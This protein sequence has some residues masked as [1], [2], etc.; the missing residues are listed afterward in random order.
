MSTFLSKT[1][2]FN[3]LIT[4]V[5]V[6]ESPAEAADHRGWMAEYRAHMVRKQAQ[7]TEDPE[8]RIKYAMEI[9]HY[10]VEAAFQY[11][12][13]DRRRAWMAEE[14]ARTTK[15]PIQAA[16]ERARVAEYRAQSTNWLL[17][18]IKK[19][20]CTVQDDEDKKR[21]IVVSF[22]SFHITRYRNL[23][24]EE[25]AR[26][27]KN[28]DQAAVEYAQIAEKYAKA[29]DEDRDNRHPSDPEK[30]F[31][32]EYVYFLADL[33]AEA[34]VYRADAAEYQAHMITKFGQTM[35]NLNSDCILPDPLITKRDALVND[36]YD[37]AAAKQNLAAK[38]RTDAVKERAHTI[39]CTV[40]ALGATQNPA[41]A[42]QYHVWSVEYLTYIAKYS[43]NSTPA[44][45]AKWETLRDMLRLMEI[46]QGFQE[47]ITAKK[48]SIVIVGQL[49]SFQIICPL[50]T[51]LKSDFDK[52]LSEALR[53]RHL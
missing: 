30:S 44:Q 37:Q 21:E 3:S 35:K 8:Q 51:F 2:R 1:D 23:A 20:V 6:I 7:A 4:D 5:P 9:S 15:D 41:W 38:Y 36:C 19:R 11:S 42:V 39:I 10:Q 18:S 17:Q 52:A 27:A 31:K 45:A 47:L 48:A 14:R 28:P 32:G 43:E 46:L 16:E 40:Q 25:R 22:C 12:Y 29:I 34:L 13:A 49:D 24:A 50:L 33:L 53:E 26:A